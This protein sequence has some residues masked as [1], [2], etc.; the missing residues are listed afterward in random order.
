MITKLQKRKMIKIA[1][2]IN[3]VTTR[4]LCD[5]KDFYKETKESIENSIRNNINANHAFLIKNIELFQTDRDKITGAITL[6][7]TFYK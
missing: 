4:L 1:E 7:V 6:H 5:K 3:N 2:N